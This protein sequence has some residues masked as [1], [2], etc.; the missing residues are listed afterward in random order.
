M[1]RMHFLQKLWGKAQLG[2][3]RWCLRGTQMLERSVHKWPYHTSSF[4]V[5]HCYQIVPVQWW[6]KR[7]Y[8]RLCCVDCVI[9]SGRWSSVERYLN[10]RISNFSFVADNATLN[11]GFGWDEP[12][13]TERPEYFANK[14]TLDASESSFLIIKISSVFFQPFWQ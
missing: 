13:H 14:I 1:R 5:P 7:G 10:P 8:V 12:Y 11:V 2:S 9:R 3:C 4:R 6:V